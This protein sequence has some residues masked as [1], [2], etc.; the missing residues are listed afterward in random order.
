MATFGEKLDR[1]A[2]QATC[3]ALAAGGLS[4]I[5]YGAVGLAAGGAG[6]VPIAAGSLALLAAA[7]GCNWDPNNPG[8]PPQKEGRIGGCLQVA[9][10]AQ[11]IFQGNGGSTPTNP[12]LEW[13]RLDSAIFEG[14][15]D[16]GDSLYQLSGLNS[17]GTLSTLNGVKVNKDYEPGYFTL[18]SGPG[19]PCTNDEPIPDIPPP[20]IPPYE[21]TDPDD[22]CQLTV[23][24][25]GF[26]QDPTGAIN[27]VFKIEPGP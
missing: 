4:L 9:V 3:A 25:E 16:D 26:Q 2:G 6:V 11:V 7:G 22:G 17:T 5:R 1:A 20:E 23:N 21:Y 27:P 12:F 24:L 18:D 13:R 8:P 14:T 10:R 19:N 15:N